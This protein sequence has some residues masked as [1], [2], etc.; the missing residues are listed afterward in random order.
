MASFLTVAVGLAFTLGVCLLV[1]RALLEPWLRFRR[2]P[3]DQT[4][5][6]GKHDTGYHNTGY[7]PTSRATRTRGAQPLHTA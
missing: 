3:A 7:K 5:D 2:T 6:T 4:H 1:L